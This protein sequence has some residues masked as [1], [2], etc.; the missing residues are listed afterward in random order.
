MWDMRVEFTIARRGQVI[1]SL[2]NWW[3]FSS[4]KKRHERIWVMCIR[5]EK[6]KSE[7]HAMNSGWAYRMDKSTYKCP[8]CGSWHLTKVT[9]GE[10]KTQKPG[11]IA[12]Q[13]IKEQESSL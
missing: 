1:F 6:F 10:A 4:L 7:Q 13:I 9:P 2:S 11:R 3:P 8:N 5:K 12:R